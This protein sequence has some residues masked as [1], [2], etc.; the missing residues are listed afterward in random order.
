MMRA[1]RPPRLLV[2]FAGLVAILLI[3]PTLVVIPMSFTNRNTFVFPP[4][5]FSTQWYSNFF[6]DPAWTQSAL[7][8]LK[9]AAVVVV[10]ATVLGTLAALALV[11]GRGLWKAPT[12]ALLIA[13]MIV[14]GVITAIAIYY[15]FLKWQLTESFMGFVL[16]H[17]VLA[18][19]LVIIPV[20][21][22]L[23]GFDRDLEKAASSLGA[24]PFAAFRRVTLPLILPGVLTGAL[25]AFLTSFDEAIV[26][27]FL[28]GPTAR[29]LPV[30]MYQS[31]TTEVDPT[32]AAAS[33]LLIVLST[34]LLFIGAIVFSRR[35]TRSV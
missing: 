29:T 28:S 15:V 16:A 10:L 4:K 8:S 3:A 31:V 19:P 26:S 13:P 9:V 7:L 32:I 5:G 14:P 12:R 34:T 20:T 23:V 6:S 21:A 27:L 11:R 2:A 33:T 22:S 25:F 35:R 18:I 24:G 30:Q 17:T 1:E